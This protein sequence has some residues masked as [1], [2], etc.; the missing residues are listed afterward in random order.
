MA[1][2]RYGQALHARVP[3]GARL[4]DQHARC[5]GRQGRSPVLQGYRSCG[6][7]QDDRHLPEARQLDAA[8]GNHEARLRG[9]ARHLPA[10]RPD[11]QAP[12]L[13]RRGGGAAGLRGAREMKETIGWIGVGSMGHRMSRHLA[14]AGYPLVVADAVST[15]R[16]PPGAGIAKS[17]AEVAA[18]AA[19]VILSLPDGKV[20]EAVAAELAAAP[21]R[22]VKTVIDTSTIGIT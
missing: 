11:H 9:G 2:H 14:T 16:A 17:N 10:R 12:C 15:E 6:A 5:R 20:S 22:K 4:A 1:R 7:D 8:R 19:T 3:Q 21:D 18:R 13:R